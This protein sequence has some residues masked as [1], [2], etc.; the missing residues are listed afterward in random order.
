[1]GERQEEF[2]SKNNKKYCV[3]FER[4]VNL[5]QTSAAVA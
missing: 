1:V 3:L 5:G 4:N 2:S